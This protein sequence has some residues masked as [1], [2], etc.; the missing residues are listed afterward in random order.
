VLFSHIKS[1]PA[2]SKPAVLFYYSKSASATA[3]QTGM[4]PAAFYSIVA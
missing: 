4:I 3:S 2:T 1:T